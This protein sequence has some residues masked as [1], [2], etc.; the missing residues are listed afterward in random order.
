MGVSVR[1]PYVAVLPHPASLFGLEQFTWIMEEPDTK[2]NKSSFM[3][4]TMKTI[5]G[6]T[7]SQLLR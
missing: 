7:T 3:R 1:P 4:V 2:L 6:K 5:L